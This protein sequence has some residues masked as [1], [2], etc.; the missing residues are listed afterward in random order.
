MSYDRLK[1]YLS[2]PVNKAAHNE[3]CKAWR[4]DNVELWAYTMLKAR[5]KRE[6]IPFDLNVSDV[7]VPSHC[8]ILGMP[9]VR[10]K[11]RG[12]KADSPSVDRIDPS[13]GYTKGNV[14]VVSQLANRMK[15]NAT[16]E[17]LHQFAD[18]VKR[19]V[20]HNT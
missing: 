16:P 5:A 17:Q 9:L 6:G 2:N 12:P 15:N 20:I 14:W 18:W 4:A 19:S 7:S 13:K 11:G 10:S 3:R 1:K 8:P